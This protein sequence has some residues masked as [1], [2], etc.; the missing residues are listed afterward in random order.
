M[1]NNKIEIHTI[2]KKIITGI[3]KEVNIETDGTITRKVE[4][5]SDG[6]MKDKVIE[7]NDKEIYI[8]ANIE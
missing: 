7:I 1:L 2:D 4:V 5:T 8:I 6:N 3:L